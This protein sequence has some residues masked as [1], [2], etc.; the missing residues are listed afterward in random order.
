DAYRLADGVPSVSP[1][2]AVLGTAMLCGVEAG[3]VAADAALAAGLVTDADLRECLQRFFRHPSIRDARLVVDLADGRSESPGE[4]RARLVLRSL[5][6]GA[7]VPQVE[8]REDN[9]RLVARVD[10]LYEQQR[11]IVEFD[12]LVKYGGADGHKALVAEKRREDRLRDLGFQVVRVT[13]AEL[14][15]PI[16]LQHRIQAAFARTTAA[17]RSS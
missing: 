16:L 8:I 1:G 11:T 13:W 6:L 12:G 4:S 5:A 9:G 7:V 17:E 3:V 14:D 2:L 15:R 10:F